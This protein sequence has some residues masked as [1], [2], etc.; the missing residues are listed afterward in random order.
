M[1]EPPL[2][3]PVLAQG[4]T[5][6]LYPLSVIK[7]RQMALEGSQR[8]LRV[9]AGAAQGQHRR[10]RGRGADRACKAGLSRG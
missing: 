4:L 6:C 10:G 8:G 5:T 7:T 9:G 3:V 1:D 2:T